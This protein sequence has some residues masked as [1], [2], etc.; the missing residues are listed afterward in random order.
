MDEDWNEEVGIVIT[1]NHTAR[2][3]KPA[4]FGHDT[5]SKDI[6]DKWISDDF[7]F[8]IFCPDI[9]QFDLKFHN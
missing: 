1:T 4:D 9:S 7:Y 8:D 2:R 6:Y 3:C 5:Q